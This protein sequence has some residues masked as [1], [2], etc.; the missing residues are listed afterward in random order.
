MLNALLPH[1]EY[2][3]APVCRRK[4]NSALDTIK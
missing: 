1:N 2:G 4:E 3:A